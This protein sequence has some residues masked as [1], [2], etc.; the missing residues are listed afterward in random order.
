MTFR[1]SIILLLIALSCAEVAAQA[2][3]MVSP[4]ATKPATAVVDTAAD[5]AA[6]TV[7]AQPSAA[8][9]IADTANPVVPKTA[10]PQF[11]L[12]RLPIGNGAE[13]LTIF[14]RLDSMRTTDAATPEVP[15][16]S[17]VR[18]TLADTDPDNDRLSYVWM[19]TYTRPNLMKRF[20]SA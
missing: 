20:A 13:L 16:I 2:P 18:D 10:T 9:E 14:G 1:P 8:N 4:A 15:L 5:P 17:V 12:E 7:T 6:K 19:L 3:F 11:R